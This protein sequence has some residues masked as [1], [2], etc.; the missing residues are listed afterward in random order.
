MRGAE[1]FTGYEDKPHEECGVFGIYAPG[2]PVAELTYL[3][4]LQLQHRGHEGAG[5]SVIDNEGRFWGT[6]E[7][8]EAHV[9]LDGG[10]KLTSLP[11]ASIASGHV[12]YGTTRANGN[13]EDKESRAL[14]PMPGGPKGRQ[15][16][17]S[18]NGH[19]VNLDE[20]SPAFSNSSGLT[21]DSELIVKLI[22]REL[23]NNSDAELREAVG[24]AANHLDGAFSLVITGKDKLIGLRDPKGFKPLWLGEL[25][26]DSW[27]LASEVAA[28]KAVD[29]KPHREI[30]AGELV[31]I[32]ADGVRSYKPFPESEV[33]QRLCAFELIYNSRPDNVMLG[34][35][36]ERSRLRSG[37]LLARR[38][39]VDA[40]MVAGSPESGI[41][42][43][44]GYA[45]ESGL[46]M[47]RGLVKNPY[48]GRTFISPGQPEREKKVKVKFNADEE[49]VAGQRVVLVDDS[50]IRG[51][52]TRG[53]VNMLRAA[54]A[55]EVHVRIASA[56]YRWPCF[57]G[58]DTGRIDELIA[59][60]MSKEEIG[61]F[62]RAD[63]LEFLSVADLEEAMP[64]AAGKLCL[65]CMTGE[66]P[67]EIPHHLLSAQ[68]ANSS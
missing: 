20:L 24:R 19:I 58:M 13:D 57:M 45:R 34:E 5:V 10:K 1:S 31:E 35:S 54:G 66:Y 48:V 17:V 26:N 51:T 32:G 56:P 40:D 38:F 15:F 30:E 7:L 55:A 49:I 29:A 43:A 62:I 8:G 60:S 68:A 67:I 28:L 3:G 46:L 14:Q 41:S 64:R 37:Q 52:T 2:K 59:A 33:E 36:A 23:D 27:V 53:I 44:H 61:T 6:A 63:S 65:A 12:R 42:A 47:E 4:L 50:I 21:T 25:D 39:P 16:S 11:P 22:G 9:G 18:H